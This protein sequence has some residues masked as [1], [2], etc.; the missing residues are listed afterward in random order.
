MTA[1]AS[2]GS[3]PTPVSADSITASVPSNTAL[4]TSD[5]SARVGYAAVTIDSSIWVAVITGRPA[6]MADRTRRFWRWGTSSIGNHDLGPLGA[7]GVDEALDVGRPLDERGRHR[8]GP[9]V[10]GG[11]RQVEVARRGAGDAADPVGQVDAGPALQVAAAPDHEPD[12]PRQGAGVAIDGVDR[13]D[14]V[15]LVDLEHDGAVARHDPVA[16]GQPEA[17]EVDADD[18]G[19]ALGRTAREREP[20]ARD[21]RHAAV[22]ERR[23]AQLGPRQIDEHADVAVLLGADAPHPLDERELGGGLAVREIDPDH[24]R[25]GR[26]H[27]AQDGLVP[28]GRSDGRHDLRSPL[29]LSHCLSFRITRSGAPGSA[30]LP[31]PG[32][33]SPSTFDRTYV[34]EVTFDATGVCGGPPAGMPGR[35]CRVRGRSVTIASVFRLG[36]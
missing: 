20:V 7:E 19:T 27:L 22:G 29:W 1:T 35:M 15:D 16:D 11:P 36:T 26:D 30:A 9:R 10:A 3:A 6:A 23:H 21:Q 34:T 14:R 28:R 24:V 2:A 18:R 32:C 17:G 4:A 33:C 31:V 13:V 5:T 12:P 25:A 8:V